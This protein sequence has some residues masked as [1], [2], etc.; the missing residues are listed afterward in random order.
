MIKII[1]MKCAEGRKAE[2]DYRKKRR[3]SHWCGDRLVTV[4]HSCG[5]CV[6]GDNVK[7]KK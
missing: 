4:G 6:E 1:G 5:W 2:S 7:R 3:A